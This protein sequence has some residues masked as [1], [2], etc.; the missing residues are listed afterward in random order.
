MPNGKAK[1]AAIDFFFIVVRIY[2]IPNLRIFEEKGRQE[3]DERTKMK[4]F[5]AVFRME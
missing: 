1:R 2:Q 5:C 4:E 3:F